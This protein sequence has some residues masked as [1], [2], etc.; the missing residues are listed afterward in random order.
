MTYTQSLCSSVV[1]PISWAAFG[2]RLR[3]WSITLARRAASGRKYGIIF[4][5]RT[6]GNLLLFFVYLNHD[7]NLM[8]KQ[9]PMKVFVEIKCLPTWYQENW[10]M[11]SLFWWTSSHWWWIRGTLYYFLKVQKKKSGRKLT[12]DWYCKISDLRKPVKNSQENQRYILKRTGNM[13]KIKQ[14]QSKKY[15]D[16]SFW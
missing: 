12:K 9:I 10:S 1:I 15:L 11:C 3:S 2:S 7:P 16:L 14:G 6:F 4:F 13:R 5:I 8:M